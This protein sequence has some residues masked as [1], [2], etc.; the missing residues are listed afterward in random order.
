MSLTLET[1]SEQFMTLVAPA[2]D[3]ILFIRRI[4][5]VEARLQESARW[6]W[7]KAEVDFDVED[8]H[9]YLDPDLYASLI[10]VIFEDSGRVIRPRDM[11]FAP[12]AVGRPT[13]GA[14]GDGYLVDC[15]IVDR[16]VDGE[17]VKR[18]KYKIVDVTSNANTVTGL[19]H[20]AHRRLEDPG[21]IAACPSSR[22]LKLG[23]Y[24]VQYEEVNDLERAD[25]MWQQAYQALNENEKATRGGVRAVLPIQPFGEGIEPVGA[26][27]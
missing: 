2:D 8:G 6:H 22:A 23:L 19:A 21:D 7:T 3:D 13:G 11:E 1:L 18:R 20:L 14:G 17:T 9:V 16:T 10:G 12:G 27:M 5:E 26:I 24:A 4:N 25:A 15:G